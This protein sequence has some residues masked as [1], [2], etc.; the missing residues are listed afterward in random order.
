VLPPVHRARSYGFVH[1]ARPRTTE[2]IRA[3]GERAG[4]PLLD[5]A[6][7]TGEHVLAGHGNPDGMH[8]GWDA[9]QVVGEAL[10][11]TIR[12]LLPSETHP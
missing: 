12:T 6:A 10:A 5:F 8:W 7:L 11:A 2:A 4:V 3:W 1:T 9:H